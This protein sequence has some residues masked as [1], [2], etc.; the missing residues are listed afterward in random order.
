MQVHASVRRQR[1]DVRGTRT[2]G[3]AFQSQPASRVGKLLRRKY[4]VHSLETPQGSLR[5]FR[6]GGAAVFH[7]LRRNGR[8]G[9][10]RLAGR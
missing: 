8:V 4:V 9:G 7:L 10:R 1:H 2:P 5:K 6:Q 3:A